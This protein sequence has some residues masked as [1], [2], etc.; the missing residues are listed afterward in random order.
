MKGKK[1][2]DEFRQ[3][4]VDE[5]KFTSKDVKALKR[6]IRQTQ[7]GKRNPKKAMTIFAGK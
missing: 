6:E 1:Y 4:I 7:R 3:M 5:H 2:S